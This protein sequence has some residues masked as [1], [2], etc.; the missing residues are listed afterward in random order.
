MS[1]KVAGP[2][3]FFSR[4]GG[5]QP[6]PPEF[7]AAMGRK[8]EV[9]ANPNDVG[10]EALSDTIVE[11]EVKTDRTGE[12]IRRTIKKNAGPIGPLS[13]IHT[14]EHGQQ[15]QA[16]RL[17]YATG[18]V[19]QTVPNAYTTVSTQDLGN[20]WTIEE[21]SVGGVY[22]G[23][24]PFFTPGLFTAPAFERTNPPGIPPEYLA[25]IDV[26]TTSVDAAGTAV[27][28]NK[29]T[30]GKYKETQTQVTQYKKRTEVTTQTQP[31]IPS[32]L[33]KGKETNQAK[34]I[35]TV[36]RTLLDDA[37]LP[38]V[39]TETKEVTVRQF[40]EGHKE[41]VTKTVPT[42]FPATVVSKE[43]AD[44]FPPEFVTGTPNLLSETTAAGIVAG[45]S[46][47][48][49]ELLH[50]ESQVDAF[51][52][53]TRTVN[54]TATLPV[55]LND[56]ELEGLRVGGMLFNGTV[57]ITRKLSSAGQSISLGFR[58]LFSKVKALGA[59]HSLLE[60]GTVDAFPTA[61]DNIVDPETGAIVNRTKTI[62]PAGTS[63]PGTA[64]TTQEQ[65]NRDHLVR[66]VETADATSFAN[67]V[68]KFEGF[69][70]VD[71]PPQLLVVNGT[72]P[73]GGGSGSFSEGGFFNITGA[74]SGS[75][76]LAGQ[77]NASDTL[78][79]D[80]YFDIKQPWGNN[81]PCTH[82]LFFVVSSETRANVIAKCTTLLGSTVNDWPLFAPRA[83]NF[84]CVGENASATA[85]A[86]ASKTATIRVNYSG[87]PI[88]PSTAESNGG[89][90]SLESTKTVRIV[91]LPPVIHGTLNSVNGGFVGLFA[92]LVGAGHIAQAQITTV[93]NGQV[94]SATAQATGFITPTAL[95]ATSGQATIPTS[96][97]Y[98]SRLFSEPAA[99]GY[100]KMHAEIISFANVL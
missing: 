39:P 68:R 56:L 41:Q 74:G 93:G 63:H 50:A 15:V 35:V 60:T 99:Q 83:V 43:I 13:F 40:G 77:A 30:G 78:S 75:L 25:N 73:T 87:D 14:D 55:I 36:V 6:I 84:V 47:G 34:Q 16:T 37:T 97:F 76:S 52:K 26:I 12:R 38:E 22:G 53:K 92:N 90:G 85:R 88:G 9:Q 95:G 33:D 80:V 24:D 17:M 51:T 67:Y 46:L 18:T 10:P 1:N 32:T 49:N 5:E 58:T 19:Q 7:L 28:P 3:L 70:N 64:F 44:L 65:V 100:I 98:L 20:G 94:F 2:K 29:L 23:V 86:T 72:S 62:Q 91:R 21:A 8:E 4:F 59:S 27:T 54:R 89:G 69:T 61:I 31:D 79:P 82:L 96:G 45:P 66:V 48:A 11:S 42:V 81:I 57:T 71:L